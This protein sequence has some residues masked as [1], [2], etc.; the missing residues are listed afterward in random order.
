MERSWKPFVQNRVS[1]I[2]SLFP[3]ECWNHIAGVENPA[4]IPS[5]GTTP[6]ELMINKL[7]RNGPEI[8]LIHS[9]KPINADVPPECLEELRASERRAVH[10]LLTSGIVKPCI[11]KLIEIEK[12]SNL[13]RLINI[14]T[15]V[16]RFCA[17]L[18]R[19]TGTSSF[20]GGERNFA[21]TLLILEAQ[22]P[23]RGHKNFSMWKKQ[24]SLFEEDSGILRCRGRID[25]A[26]N[27]PYSTKHPIILPGDHHLTTLY[28]RQAHA[29]V[30][31]NGVKETLTE[32]RSQFWV[33][34]GLSL[35][36]I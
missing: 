26:S 14:L 29:R 28:V 6:L 1:E 11:G 36:H 17:K 5:R 12:F 10:G 22:A 27:L 25:N 33:I 16:L 7:W 20:K 21:E 18:R 4:D 23:L 2:R 31:H 24:L 19:K 3:V 8:P 32:L 9:A 35:I 15:C 13:P 34:K 30:L